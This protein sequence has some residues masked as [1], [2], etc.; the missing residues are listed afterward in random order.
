M[1]TSCSDDFLEEKMVSVITQDYFKTEQGLDQ[2]VVATYNAERLRHPYTEGGFSFEL[3]H[4]C[5][6]ASGSNTINQFS[7]AQ[8]TATGPWNSVAGYMN[9]FMGVQSKQQSGFI[10]NC[11]PVIDVCNKAIGSIR[12]GSAVGKYASD[13]A[14]AASRLSEALFNRDYL[15]FTLNTLLGDVYFPQTSITSLPGNFCYNRMPSEEA[16]KIMIGDMRYAVENLPE[17]A[18]QFGRITKYA[19]AHFLTKLYLTRAQGAECGTAEY[20]SN[21]DG[22]IDNLHPKAYLGM[23]YKGK[24]STDLDSCI[25]YASMVINSQKYELEPDYLNLWQNDIDSWKNEESKEI[26]LAGVFGNGTDNYRYGQRAC[27]LFAQ[28]YVNQKWGIPDYTWQN[29]TKENTSY[30]NYDWGVDVF[31]D[32]LNDARFQKSFHLEFTTAL[33]GGTKSTKAEDI[34]YYAYNDEHNATYTWTEAQANYFNA[35]ILPNYDRAS[36][37]GRAAVVGVFLLG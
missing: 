37:G 1:M 2:L 7:T 13:K 30:R 9:T 10:I 5:G 12:G 19:A 3:G 28:T 31:T 18:E 11:Y 35:N 25:Y 27:C 32:K 29:P 22:T 16:W 15:I 33:N 20:G 17:E 26:I 36:W 4:D 14:Y 6:V 21:S 34:P 8:W 23:L 24:V